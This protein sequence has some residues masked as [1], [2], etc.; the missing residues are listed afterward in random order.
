MKTVDGDLEL[1][2]LSSEALPAAL[3]KA[4]RYRLLNE[5]HQAASICRDILRQAPEDQAALEHLILAIT[6]Q[7]EKP[8]RA[9]PRAARD[10]LPRL[11]GEYRRRYYEGIIF[12]REARACLHRN[13]PQCGEIAYAGF[14]EAMGCYEAAEEIRPE[15]NDDAR[16]R[17]NTCV[18]AIRDIPHLSA[19][20]EDDFRPLLE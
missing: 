1:K 2:P 12:E 5:P 13:N 17:W 10:L 19:P 9:A 6:E 4:V 14:R 3:R 16:L 15:G 20:V 7:F 18:R 11:D 8:P